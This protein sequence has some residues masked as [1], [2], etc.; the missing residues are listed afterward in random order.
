MSH[1][2]IIS[3]LFAIALVC[4]C[5]T[6]PQT[7]QYDSLSQHVDALV[8]AHE[9]GAALRIID[10]NASTDSNPELRITLREQTIQAARRYEQDSIDAAARLQESDQWGASL[11]L[12]EQRLQHFP[13]SR[14]LAD[15]A[16]IA[17][18]ER[19]EFVH[20][21]T[22]ELY[23]R[24]AQRLNDE[25]ISVQALRAAS[26]EQIQLPMQLLESLLSE[27]DTVA[28]TL[29]AEGERL[30]ARGQYPQAVKLLTL[31]RALRKDERVE[32]ALRVTQRKLRPRPVK[33]SASAKASLGPAAKSKLVEELALQ[34]KIR[35]ATRKVGAALQENRLFVAKNELAALHKLDADNAETKRLQTRLDGLFAK[36][37]TRRLEE[38]EYEYAQGNI[39]A[40]IR[41]WQVA[42]QIRPDD[43]SLS[44]RLEKAQRFKQRYEALR[45]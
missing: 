13:E 40:A 20:Q 3:S 26:D 37:L 36:V 22:V 28:S 32:T 31:S 33:A 24:R 8:Q 9:F 27:R 25:I 5:A 12:Y 41:H 7:R 6:A 15:A 2:R 1:T 19:D 21:T 34:Q 10:K 23:T 39:D 42:Q 11:A 4:G 35:T 45:E 29:L 14:R 38:G 16:A 18:R 43:E 17:R 30:S 44:E